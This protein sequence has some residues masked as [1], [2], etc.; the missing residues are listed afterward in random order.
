VIKLE[1]SSSCWSIVPLNVV[2]A[3]DEDWAVPPFE[4]RLEDGKIYGRGVQDMKSVSVSL[5]FEL[6]L[7]LVELVENEKI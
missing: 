3:P 6:M 1:K 5:I 7:R 2:P 4:G